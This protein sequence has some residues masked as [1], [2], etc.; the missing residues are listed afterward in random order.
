MTIDPNDLNQDGV[1]T[2]D[3]LDVV[4]A[5]GRPKSFLRILAENGPRLLTPASTAAAIPFLGT[6]LMN[7]RQ[8]SQRRDALSRQYPGA[9]SEAALSAGRNAAANADK[10]ASSASASVTPASATSPTTG[11]AT[12]SATGE[13]P[14]PGS[15]EKKTKLDSGYLGVDEMAGASA[16]TS[17]VGEDGVTRYW[18][19]T[20]DG[21]RQVLYK[22]QD[23]YKSLAG[24]GPKELLQWRKAMWLGGYME[25][26][27]F[28]GPVTMDD[29][30][31]MQSVMTEANMTG[32][33][34][35]GATASRIEMGARYGRPITEAEIAELDDDVPALIKDYAS[36]N[37]INVSDDFIARQQK[38][39]L[40]GKDTPE[41]VLAKLRDTYVKPMYP[42]FEKE[43]DNGLT[44]QD[45]A[46]PYID[47]VAQFLEI[48]ASQ[49]DLN[50]PTI[51]KALQARDQSGQPVRMSLW[52]LEDELTKDPRW[53]YTDNAY[54]AYESAVGGMISEMGL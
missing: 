50:D 3:E 17:T 8:Y 2:R 54:R 25:P 32:N 52:E 5:Q 1:V 48:P 51:K 37:G 33:T 11:A 9:P 45:I 12:A 46:S 28:V 39:V 24:M 38:R 4:T 29:L 49:I 7:S 18:V 22:E 40:N 23:A 20:K 26:K 27:S 44:V 15:S 10:A 34:W 30:A 21:A 47:T 6:E 41:T 35:E 36:K 43:L 16:V 31:T 13:I 14:F 42:Q 53:Q 19:D